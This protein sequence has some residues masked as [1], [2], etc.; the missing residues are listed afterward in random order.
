MIGLGTREVASREMRG[1]GPWHPARGAGWLR[2]GGRR[3]APPRRRV[4][5]GRPPG[6]VDVDASETRR[7][8]VSLDGVRLC[9]RRR[10]VPGTRRERR[11]RMTHRVRAHAC[12]HRTS[13][14]A[15]RARRR[16]VA[17]TR[18]ARRA[19][20]V[21]LLACSDA[22]SR[23][24][25]ASSRALR[26]RDA[27]RARRAAVVVARVPRRAH[28]RDGAG[29]AEVVR[30]SGARSL[31]TALGLPREEGAAGATA[32]RAAPPPRRWRGRTTAPGRARRRTRRRAASA[33]VTRVRSGR[34]GDQKAGGVK[35]QTMNG[36]DA[37]RL[38]VFE[39]RVEVFG[40]RWLE[41]GAQGHGR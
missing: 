28:S 2:L 25:R 17:R 35:D 22:T 19:E 32:L 34:R 11:V 9:A 1:V 23:A 8:G 20:F 36:T 40:L 27:L 21:D 6:R 18:A 38:S 26:V 13:R 37:R 15:S 7:G 41:A 16:C 3:R 4:A 14:I 33:P 31:A 39:A 30:P 12:R 29:F 24:R 5:R 10:R